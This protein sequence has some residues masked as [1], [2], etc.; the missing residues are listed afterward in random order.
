[1]ED[2]EVDD[3]QVEELRRWAEEL[4]AA[5]SQ[6]FEERMIR[7]AFEERL[8]DEEEE[9]LPEDLLTRLRGFLHLRRRVVE[10]EGG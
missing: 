3:G 10:S 9:E 4:L 8:A 5:R 1:V 2:E 7:Q 6:L